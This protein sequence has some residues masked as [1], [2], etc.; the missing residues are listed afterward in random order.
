[1]RRLQDSLEQLRQEI[2]HAGKPDRWLLKTHVVQPDAM[3]TSRSA[4]ILAVHAADVHTNRN[5]CALLSSTSTPTGLIRQVNRLATSLATVDQ[6][7][8]N[9]STD[10]VESCFHEV[11]EL[12][13]QTREV[14]GR[15]STIQD[16]IKNVAN[17]PGGT[18]TRALQ[19]RKDLCA[20]KKASLSSA[21]TL[22]KQIDDAQSDIAVMES[23]ATKEDLDS[24][25]CSG[26]AQEFVNNKKLLDKVLALVPLIIS[27]RCRLT[28]TCRP[29]VLFP[30]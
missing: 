12:S 13:G 29:F 18:R 21:Q 7:I 15:L 5:L 9:H 27:P 17:D 23:A 30:G 22:K 14:E 11:Q 10:V 1:M 19:N 3:D 24:R 8:R 20:Q 28:Y 16:E 4:L 25:E 2:A 26:Q 6:E